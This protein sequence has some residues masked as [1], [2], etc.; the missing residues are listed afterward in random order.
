MKGLHTGS[1]ACVAFIRNENNHCVL[2]V[3]NVGDTRAVIVSNGKAERLSIDD[4]ASYS[5]ERNRVIA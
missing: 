3:A 2:Y 5:I 1:T 4:K